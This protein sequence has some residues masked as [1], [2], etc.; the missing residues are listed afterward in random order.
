MALTQDSRPGTAADELASWD[1]TASGRR[2]GDDPFLPE[3]GFFWWLPRA[4]LMLFV[5]VAL[6]LLTASTIHRGQVRLVKSDEGMAILERGRFYPSGWT[7]F[8]PDGSVEAWA[9]VLW[10]AQSVEPPLEGELR[11]LADTY[12][13][14]VRS[15][16]A[17]HPGD[18]GLVAAMEAQEDKLQAWY[19][20]RWAGELPPQPGTVR[21]QREEREAAREAELRAA[22]EQAEAQ[23]REAERETVAEDALSRART[24]AARRRGLL[25]EAE[26]LLAG[27]PEEGSAEQ[28]RDREAIEGFI[29]S[30]DTPAE[31]ASP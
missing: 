9:P 28:S 23:A 13:G 19:S 31:Q 5:L 7:P 16:A 4:L 24:Y 18:A 21:R 22:R 29:E 11:E 15:R 12:L 6:G 27:L 10:P 8:V 20:E 26:D 2:P 30:M 17:Q 14:F 25:R 3:E 1:E